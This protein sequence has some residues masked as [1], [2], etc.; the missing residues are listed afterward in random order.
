MG[1]DDVLAGMFIGTDGRV[2]KQHGLAGEFRR[3]LFKLDRS[4]QQPIDAL[5][6]QIRVF[7]SPEISLP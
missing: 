7:A 4:A 6:F 2:A 1:A 3:R 5:R